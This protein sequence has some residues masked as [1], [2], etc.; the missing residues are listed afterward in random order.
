MKTA[1]IRYKI[2]WLIL[3]IQLILSI[4][5]NEAIYSD[6]IKLFSLRHIMDIT[7]FA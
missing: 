3:S 6:H 5:G 7:L 2:T 1:V 4:L